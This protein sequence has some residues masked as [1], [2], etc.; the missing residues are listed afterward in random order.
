MENLESQCPQTSEAWQVQGY[1]QGEL[2]L[3]GWI[4]VKSPIRIWMKY[5]TDNV[6]A[7]VRVDGCEGLFVSADTL[8]NACDSLREIIE[9]H[10]EDMNSPETNNIKRIRNFLREHLEPLVAPR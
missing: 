9:M 8:A 5:E 2:G 10:L 4:K 7:E 3:R 6:L 1:Q